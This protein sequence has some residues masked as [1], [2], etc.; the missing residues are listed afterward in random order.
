MSEDLIEYDE[1]EQ[2]SKKKRKTCPL[3]WGST[4]ED[5]INYVGMYDC[6]EENCAWWYEAKKCCSLLWLA[7]SISWM[8][9]KAGTGGG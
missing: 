1:Q 3:S 4:E 5:M 2:G 8:A 6:V 7:T 9:Y